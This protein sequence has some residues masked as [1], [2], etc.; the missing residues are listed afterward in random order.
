MLGGLLAGY[1]SDSDSS[2][3]GRIEE[4]NGN[5]EGA[6]A[7]ESAPVPLT[8]VPAFSTVLTFTAV[9]CKIGN[10]TFR[11]DLLPLTGDG[12]RPGGAVRRFVECAGET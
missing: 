10:R 2:S 9:V 11:M 6:S 4:H 12:N 7:S 8:N 3:D 5:I 1:E